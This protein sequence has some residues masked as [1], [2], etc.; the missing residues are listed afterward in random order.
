MF[1]RYVDS[2]IQHSVPSKGAE[3]RFRE[4]MEKTVE[5]CRELDRLYCVMEELL[6]IEEVKAEKE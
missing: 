1:W 2:L 5:L 3:E 4:R 6:E